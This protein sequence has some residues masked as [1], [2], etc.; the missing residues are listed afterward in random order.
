ME[1]DELLKRLN[2]LGEMM[3]ERCGTDS[4]EAR[5]YLHDIKE[6]LKESKLKDKHLNN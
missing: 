5:C 2:T 1:R 6:L 4:Y 3:Y